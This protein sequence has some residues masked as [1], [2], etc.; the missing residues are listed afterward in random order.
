MNSL[1]NR[2]VQVYNTEE[3][4]KEK[5]E[6]ERKKPPKKKKNSPTEVELTNGGGPESLW[7]VVVLEEA[8]AFCTPVTITTQTH[9]Q[10]QP[11]NEGGKEH[12]TNKHNTR[13]KNDKGVVQT[14]DYLLENKIV[15][16]F[17]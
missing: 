13:E 5:T 3:Q 4:T 14:I 17:K 6:K 12:K 2:D 16:Q 7:V 11:D 15:T 10:S 9:T 1:T 8:V